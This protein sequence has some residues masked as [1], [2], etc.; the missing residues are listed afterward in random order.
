MLNISFF[1]KKKWQFTNEN[2]NLEKETHEN[3]RRKIEW[4]FLVVLTNKPFHL[5]Y[6]R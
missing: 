1:K 6:V 3:M 5:T 4:M 2:W